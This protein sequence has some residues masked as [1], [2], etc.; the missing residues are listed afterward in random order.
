[1][2]TLIRASF[3]LAAALSAAEPF[4]PFS[5]AVVA[6]PH[7][8]ED[9]RQY[10]AT[11]LEKFARVAEKI[12]AM[13]VAGAPDFALICGDLHV[14][15][16]AEALAMLS[17]PAHVT[18]GNHESRK[19][20]Q[21]LRE[22]LPDDFQGKDFYSFKHKGCKFISLCSATCGDHVGHLSSEDIT[23]KTGQCA[24]LEKELAEA[25]THTFVFS[26][27]PP[28]PEGKDMNMFLGQNDSRFMVGLIREFRPTALFFGH[29]HRRRRFTIGESPVFVLRS[30]NWNGGFREPT[31][32]VMVRVQRDGISTE[33]VETGPA[34]KKDK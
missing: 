7:L 22:M 33:F 21:Q 8:S 19:A 31:G 28:H 34:E 25:A 6:D 17:V 5:F 3:L 32:F 24:W 20:R 4:E 26:H 12:K 9:N 29:Q 23:P 13:P 1:M 30:C 27:I 16:L 11:G 10:A 2:A 18:P 15:R 14:H